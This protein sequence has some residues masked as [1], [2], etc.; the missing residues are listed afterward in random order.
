MF[1]TQGYEHTVDKILFPKQ[2]IQK[3][4]PIQKPKKKL[5]KKK[6]KHEKKTN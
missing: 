6:N 3:L 2:I 5:L 4:N 1:Y